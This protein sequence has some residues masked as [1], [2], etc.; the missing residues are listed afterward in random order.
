VSSMP[1]TRSR[2]IASRT[3]PLHFSS[4]NFSSSD[5]EETTMPL[6]LKRKDN[7]QPKQRPPKT[8][9]VPEEIIEIS[10]DDDDPPSHLNSQ[11]AMVADF[12]RQI[13]KL[14][15][16]S[17]KQKKD[18][19]RTV[20]ELNILREE[21]QQLQ[22][23]RKPG[24]LVDAAQLADNVDCEICTSR[25]WSPYSLPGC[26]HIFC[27]SCLQDWFST[28]LAQFMN[29]NPHYNIN[30]AHNIPH[31]QGLMQNPQAANHPQIA[32]IL[33]NLL[34]PGP[35]YTC[36][37]CREPVHSRPTEAFALKA[38]VRVITAATGE[39]SPKKPIRKGKAIAAGPWDGFFPPQKT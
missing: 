8:T 9:I 21:N 1:A 13:N 39:N 29:A 22:A 36:P 17:V 20:R 7:T 15:E 35:Q 11:A 19:E 38:I 5:I 6:T 34:P 12:R 27:Q 33:A 24:T 30:Q 37:T 2:S 10:D 32:G 16:E 3:D 28:T 25:M 14:R 18:H 26:G 31:L 4:P 23:L